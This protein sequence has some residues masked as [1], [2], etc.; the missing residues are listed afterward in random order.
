MYGKIAYRESWI[1]LSFGE[2]KQN[3][4]ILVCLLK[5]DVR[6]FQVWNLNIAELFQVISL[7][8]K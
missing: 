1:D 6:M 3:G 7:S 4:D 5:N 2:Y 8:K